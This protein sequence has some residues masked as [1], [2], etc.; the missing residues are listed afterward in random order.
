M[1]QKTPMSFDAAQWEI[2]APSCGARVVMG[3]PGVYRDP[4]GLIAAIER[5]AH[6]GK[7]AD[8]PAGQYRYADGAPERIS[9]ELIEKK[10]VI[11]INQQVYERSSLGITVA[12][13]RP[14][15]WLTY[16]DLGRK[17]QQLQMNDV[18][19]GFMSSGYSSRSGDD[20]PAARRMG[21]ILAGCGRPPAESSYFFVG[22]RVSDEQVHS[23][24]MKED[25]VHTAEYTDT[26][27]DAYR[28]Q[29]YLT[30]LF[31]VFAGTITGPA[32]EECLRVVHDEESFAEFIGA[33]FEGLDPDLVR[34][35]T[36]IV[37]QTYHFEYTFHELAE[38]TIDAPVTIFKA[39]G[40]DYSFLENS[41]GYS[42]R[43]PTVLELEADHYSMLRE[44]GLDELTGLI[45]RRLER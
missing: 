19:L 38:R 36:R 2:L 23:E 8:L 42:A 41:T 29:A 33:R 13:E 30:I 43:P 25:A 6:P 11:A 24:G 15:S 26:G 32:L 18:N 17:L 9:A 12:S 21:A 39:R 40:D 7:I 16:I 20:L 1:L 35:V 5:Q 10:H 44:P 14:E 28:D 3:R 22:G 45:H 27:G 34:R 31:S 4:G 37:H